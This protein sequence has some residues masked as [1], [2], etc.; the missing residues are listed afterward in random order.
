VDARAAKL[1]PAEHVT[2]VQKGGRSVLLDLDR[3]RYLG[4][5]EVGTRVWESLHE[6]LAFDAIVERLAEEYDAPRERIEADVE[7]FL[8]RLLECRLVEDR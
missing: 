7:Q 2:R 6:G 4:M 1:Y 5:D 8:G 3:E